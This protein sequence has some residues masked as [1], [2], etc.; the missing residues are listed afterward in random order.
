MAGKAAADGR[1]R[2]P[3]KPRQQDEPVMNKT[4]Q[5]ERALNNAPGLPKFNSRTGRVVALT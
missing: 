5:P 4:G 1:A 3:G 2:E